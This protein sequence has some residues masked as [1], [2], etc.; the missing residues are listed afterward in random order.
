MD[1]FYLR[2]GIPKSLAQVW[3]WLK[4]ED[5]A[6]L[7]SQ[8]RENQSMAKMKWFKTQVDEMCFRFNLEYRYTVL[9]RGVQ[10]WLFDMV[11]SARRS[12]KW[13][14]WEKTLRTNFV[15]FGWSSVDLV[16]QVEH[17][18]L[19]LDFFG[20]DRSGWSGGPVW[21][22]WGLTANCLIRPVWG[23]DL[24]GLHWQLQR[25]VFFL[26]WGIYTP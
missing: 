7:E 6:M 11:K 4:R 2:V 19:G 22:V 12:P 20:P 9:S 10:H 8:V 14:F 21:P 1:I 17:I 24:T 25:L 15:L 13:E 23:T 18:N 26:K 5:H 3:V 16:D